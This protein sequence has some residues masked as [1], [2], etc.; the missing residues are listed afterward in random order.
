MSFTVT[1]LAQT[2]PCNVERQKA[3]SFSQDTPTDKVIAT[4][5]GKTCDT[6]MTRIRILDATGRLLYRY[7]EPLKNAFMR[8]ITKADADRAMEV[9]LG[10]DQFR[11]TSDLPEWQPE[12]N[13]TRPIRKT[14]RCLRSTIK[15]YAIGNGAR[16]LIKSGMKAIGLLCMTVSSK[17]QLKCPV[18]VPNSAPHRDVRE[19]RD[20]V[21][22]LLRSRPRVGADVKCSGIPTT[23][24]NNRKMLDSGLCVSDPLH[25]VGRGSFCAANCSTASDRNRCRQSAVKK[26]SRYEKRETE[27]SCAL[28]PGLLGNCVLLRYGVFYEVDALESE[29]INILAIGIKK[30]NK[31]IV[32]SKEIK[33]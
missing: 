19:A 17:K 31:L 22:Y 23:C 26:P 18:A 20:S 2:T 15:T 33:I 8:K 6:A 5:R 32:A 30:G 24:P 21:N 13:T 27:S 28:I 4:I 14:S 11:S 29:L 10:E 1:A 9:I 7:S 12:S 25:A 16:F 3:I